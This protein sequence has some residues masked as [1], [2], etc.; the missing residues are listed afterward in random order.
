[1][2]PEAALMILPPLPP[3]AAPLDLPHADVRN[4][5]ASLQKMRPNK[6]TGYCGFSVRELKDLSDEALTDLSAIFQ[7]ATTLGFPK[8]LAQARA[9]IL[10]KRVQPATMGHG[11]PIVI[12][13]T[14]YRLW[15]SVAAQSILRHWAAWMPWGVRGSLPNRDARDISYTLECLIEKA[16]AE[17]TPLAGF[18]IDIVKCFNQLPRLPLRKL[19]SHLGFRE[20]VLQLW[21]QLSACVERAPAFL[22]SLGSGLPSTTGVPEGDPLS[23][24]AQVAI[25]WLLLHR[26]Q[27]RDEQCLTS[28]DNFSWVAPKV[29]GLRSTLQGALDFCEAWALPIDWQKS[30]CWGTTKSL[31]RWWDTEAQAMLPADCSIQRVDAAKDLGV[32]YRFRKGLGWKDLGQRIDEGLRRLNCIEAEP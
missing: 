1:M 21:F 22:G 30:F 20:E 6:A 25:C 15:A 10:A 12:F 11:R 27:G 19:L 8:H 16:L 23:V 29:S 17:K 26:T 31:Q 24:V 18:S 9:A 28:V 2:L 4:W 14:L 5:R 13:S 3:E 7:R 32:S